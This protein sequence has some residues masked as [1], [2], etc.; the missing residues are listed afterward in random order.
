MRKAALVVVAV[1]VVFSSLS[2]SFGAADQECVLLPGSEV[3]IPVDQTI[4]LGIITIDANGNWHDIDVT[5]GVQWTMNGNVGDDPS[6]GKLITQLGL[7]RATYKAPHTTGD[8]S[9]TAT[10][11]ASLRAP[12][13]QLPSPLLI[14]RRERFPERLKDRS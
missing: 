3:T 12:K 4:N 1:A 13:P 14:R 9:L 2:L 8:C 5:Q 11:I 10:T 6:E 7:L